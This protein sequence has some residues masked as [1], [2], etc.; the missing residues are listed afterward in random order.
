MNR[1]QLP[2]DV[3]RRTV[4]SI[5]ATALTLAGTVM[6]IR[7]RIVGALHKSALIEDPIGSAV[8][9]FA[10]SFHDLAFILCGFTLFATAGLTLANRPAAQ[11]RLTRTFFA[12]S[13]GLLAVYIAHISVMKFLFKPFTY[14]WL[15]Y[16]DF[17]GS[18]DAHQAIAANMNGEMIAVAGALVALFLIGRWL[19]GRI[20]AR[21][22]TT[23][24]AVA[25][26]GALVAAGIA[27]LVVSG[28]QLTVQKV[29]YSQTAQP[30]IAFAA[31]L[32]FGSSGVIHVADAADDVSDFVPRE[33]PSADLVQWTG[34]KTGAAAGADRQVR[35]VIFYVMESVA[36]EYVG[37]YGSMLG[38]TPELDRRR[39]EALIVSDAYAHSPTTTMSMVSLLTGTYPWVTQ[40]LVT[41]E[42]PDI[43]LTSISSL[44]KSQGYSTAFFY[45]ADLRFQKSNEFLRHRHFDRIHDY[46]SMPCD[47]APSVTKSKG[48]FSTLFWDYLDGI[49][50]D[51]AVGALSD[52]LGEVASA[53]FF[54]VLW[55]HMTHYPYMLDAAETRYVRDRDQNRYLNALRSGDRGLGRLFERLDA[56]GLAD[57]TLVVVLGDHGEAFGRHG[58][59]GHG[60][61]IYEANV[62]I[63]LVFINRTLFRG[64]TIDTVGGIAD[65]APTVAQLI[66]IER[67][68]HWQGRSLLGANRPKRT[69]FFTPW[70]DLTFGFRDA[71]M[72]YIF[73]ATYN[74]LE[75]YDLASDPWETKDLSDAY[76]DQ[77]A[78]AKARLAAW[79]QFQ[80]R[81]IRARAAP[82]TRSAK[83]VGEDSGVD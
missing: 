44:L 62:K 80:D 24:H 9:M 61:A 67:G 69:Y 56:L 25:L 39:N 20:L 47:T 70:G 71:N 49:K 11:H 53:P 28:W 38:A 4:V 15:Y 43:D 17:L 63:P 42:H 65:I 48:S 74:K 58:D 81:F 59:R 73:N 16:S 41:S 14:Q 30:I 21:L 83:N 13:L 55:T 8:T 57:S 7:G 79:V 37:L 64:E 32:P 6:L 54:A 66:G 2:A 76:P 75:V 26:P 45:A 46:R 50:D 1:E 12:L 72:K 77:V 3:Q 36:A 31:S 35:N 23:R 60:S 68:A 52:W 19:L 78:M 27:G 40:R 29:P 34:L 18:F 33:Q 51:C 5:A 82:T 22:F 10:A